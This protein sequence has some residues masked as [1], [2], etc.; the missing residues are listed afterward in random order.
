LHL[1]FYLF[2]T[3][4]YLNNT[5]SLSCGPGGSACWSCFSPHP[6]H[7]ACSSAHAVGDVCG[8]P[9]PAHPAGVGHPLPWLE[10][11]PSPAWR[12]A[13]CRLGHHT[14]GTAGTHHA[15]Q[16]TASTSVHGH[17]CRQR[18]DTCSAESICP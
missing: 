18:A 14:H 15:G 17:T 11:A 10:P 7:S 5:S 8:A 12:P 6:A 9:P 13:L 3:W 4:L 1:L 16:Q 2:K